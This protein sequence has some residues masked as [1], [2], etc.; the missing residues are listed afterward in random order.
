MYTRGMKMLQMALGSGSDSIVTNERKSMKQPASNIT[1]SMGI[2]AKSVPVLDNSQNEQSTSVTTGLAASTM[3]LFEHSVSG[4]LTSVTTGLV[5]SPLSLLDHTVSGQATSVTTGLAASTLPHLDYSVSEQST[6][7]TTGPAASI[8]PL[9]S[10]STLPLFDH[11]VSGQST[12]VTSGLAAS[13]LPLS[14]ASTLPLFDHSVSEQSTS[15]TSGLAAKS[16]VL[17]LSDSSVIDQSASVTTGANPVI[18]LLSNSPFS[19]QSASMTT[20]TAACPL[21]MSFCP[22]IE[23]SSPVTTGT[24]TGLLSDSHVNELSASLSMEPVDDPVVLTDCHLI[25]PSASLTMLSNS[26]MTE[27]AASVA[28]TSTKKKKPAR[29]CPFCEKMLPRLSRHIQTVHKDKQEVKQACSLPI[30]DRN[31][32]LKQL[33]RDGILK[34]NKKQ[35]MS[36]TPALMRER[37]RKFDSEIA[38]CN[39]CSGFFS[40]KHFW[41]HKVRCRGEST[42]LPTGIPVSLMTNISNV[43][44]TVSEEFRDKILCKLSNDEVGQLCQSDETILNVGSRLYDKMKRK[45]DKASGVAKDVRMQMRRI[46]SLF[47]TFKAVLQERDQQSSSDAS[48]MLIRSNFY[49]LEEAI[50]RR[51]VEGENETDGLKAGLKMA[52]YYLLK[53]MAKIVKASYLVQNEDSKAQ[54]VD[55]F[56]EV[57]SLNHN[58]LFGD[59]L[60]KINNTRQTK[61]RRPDKLPTE[62]DCHRLRQYTLNRVSHLISDEYTLWTATEYCELRDLVLS[63]VTLFNARRGGEPARLTLQEWN[64]ARDDGWLDSSNINHCSDIERQLFSNFK[65]TYQTGKGNNHLVPIL[66][67]ADIITAMEKLTDVAMRHSVGINTTNCYAFPSSKNSL[68]HVSGWHSIHRVSTDAKVESPELLNPTKMRH[69]VSTLYAAMDV[70][71]RDRQLFYQHM[72]HSDKVNAAIYQAPLAHQEVTN[73]G[74]HLL[75]I[76][77]CT[78]TLMLL[79]SIN[80]VAFGN[81]L[82]FLFTYLISAHCKIVVFTL[83]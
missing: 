32:M 8:L 59:A 45:K 1:A 16:V 29:P 57:L 33:K 76:D 31:N 25:E 38:M 20:E 4:Q 42:T 28:N 53:K 41:R 49:A 30:K 21:L 6:S 10:A 73:V 83:L 14:A 80:Y 70:P 78:L 50:S 82:Y 60:Y 64:N 27:P 75:Q 55:K 54:E 11:S 19:E 69:L 17:V 2:N 48:A 40:R 61:L 9:S 3:P 51:T 35:L 52:Y 26:Q 5:A 68:D 22:V 71:E 46:G 24:M 62:E 65:L 79:Q 13:I 34:F 66:F 44:H 43:K 36:G 77:N 81:Y 47:L 12:S 56:T 23:E 7:V 18:L 37:H 74:R 67:P 72:G 15:V 39:Y 63:R 58:I